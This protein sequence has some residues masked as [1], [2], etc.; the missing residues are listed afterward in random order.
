[1]LFLGTYQ[2]T[3]IRLLTN[4]QRFAEKKA[5]MDAFASG[6]NQPDNEAKKLDSELK[7][8][9]AIARHHPVG[10]RERNK[11]T[12]RLLTKIEQSGKLFCPGK[13]H[14]PPEVYANAMQA[15]RL[16]IFKSLDTYDPNKA[17]MMTWVNRKLHF[18]F[19]DAAKGYSKERT[20]KVSLSTS[21]GEDNES[22]PNRKVEQQ[23]STQ[24][25]P[26]LSEQIRQVIEDDP[27]NIFKQKCIRGRPEVDF[28]TIALKICDGYSR[29]E[30]AESFEIQEQSL[31]SFFS[32]SCKSFRLAFQNYLS[33]E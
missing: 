26:L 5:A 18:A 20:D 17:A 32:R 30:I 14:S 16:Y 21:T 27:D 3:I 28:R 31:Y 8:M 29:R 2:A 10:S 7:K 12:S 23:V 9:A 25:K 24:P 22:N 4:T 33:D 11:I 19:I 15:V 13:V 1:M 6:S